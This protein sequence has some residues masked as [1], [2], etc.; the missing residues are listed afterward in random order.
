M[1]LHLK[2]EDPER[3]RIEKSCDLVNPEEIAKYVAGA[4][5]RQG[6]IY[7][8]IEI[9]WPHPLLEVQYL[10]IIGFG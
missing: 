1:V 8:K 3:K 6:S 9:F 4:N 2:E 10:T 7:E 5:K